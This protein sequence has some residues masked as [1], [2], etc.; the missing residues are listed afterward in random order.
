MGKPSS[1][2][3]GERMEIDFHD[4]EPFHDYV[5]QSIVF[6]GRYGT[7][8]VRCAIS[9]EALQE[10]FGATGNTHAALFKAFTANHAAIEQAAS[11]KF[12]AMGG[13]FTAILLHPR[14]FDQAG[15]CSEDA[16]AFSQQRKRP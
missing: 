1:Q 10:R 11:R 13:N 3:M 14:D 5:R 4:T 9:A 15:S 8:R 2:S 12:A 7:K 6:I 16:A